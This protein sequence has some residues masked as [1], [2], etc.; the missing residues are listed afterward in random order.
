[1]SCASIIRTA[2]C[3]SKAFVWDDGDGPIAEKI[4][5]MVASEKAKDGDHFITIEWL[6]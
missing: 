6:S 5:D 3:F 2:I 4:A 1:M